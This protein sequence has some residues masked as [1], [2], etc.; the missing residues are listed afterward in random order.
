ME[1]LLSFKECNDR[2][3]GSL[4]FGYQFMMCFFGRANDDRGQFVIVELNIE[5]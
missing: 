3:L 4:S 2:M 1:N 5:T